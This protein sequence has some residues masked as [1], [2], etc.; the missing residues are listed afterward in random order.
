MNLRCL[1]MDCLTLQLDALIAKLFHM[2]SSQASSETVT[3]SSRTKLRLL[4]VTLFAID[5]LNFII[6]CPSR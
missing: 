3:H 1:M 5:M 6:R 2:L 4:K